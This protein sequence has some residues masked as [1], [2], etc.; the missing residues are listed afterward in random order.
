M[1]P[2]ILHTGELLQYIKY[3]FIFF[4]FKLNDSVLHLVVI[5]N[6]TTFSKRNSETLCIS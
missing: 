4:Q 3:I 2:T 1:N 6:T 5:C